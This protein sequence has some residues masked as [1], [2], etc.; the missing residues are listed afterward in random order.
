MSHQLMFSTFLEML[1]INIRLRLSSD[2][3]SITFS[4]FKLLFPRQWMKREKYKIEY[5]SV[6]CQIHSI[7]IF[8]L[9]RSAI[10]SA[11]SSG[12]LYFSFLSKM[13]GFRLP[14]I[15]HF[16]QAQQ[17]NCTALT[18]AKALVKVDAFY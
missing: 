10:F 8:L 3:H 5:K 13:T 9:S 17:Q 18:E 16:Y 1:C 11:S 2:I 6:L 14:T 12:V 7:A 4:S 15:L